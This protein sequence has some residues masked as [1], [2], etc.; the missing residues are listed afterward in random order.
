MSR[1]S[2]RSEAW[3]VAPILIA[4]VVVSAWTIQLRWE[5]ASS[6]P[7]QCDEIPLLTRFTGLN[8]H[9]TNEADA[10]QFEPSFYSLRMGA[11]RSLRVPPFQ[12]AIHTSTGF[13]S[14][15]S[16]HVLGYSAGAA[17][18]PQV[19]WSV[20]A[21]LATGW[22]AWLVSRSLSAACVAAWL[23]AIAPY[24]LAYGTQARGYAECM[25]LAP[26]LLIALEYF[27][28]RPDR[29][30]RAFAVFL[31]SLALSMTV[32][33]TWVYWVLPTMF[34]AVMVLP[35]LTNDRSETEQARALLGWILVALIAVMSVYTV[36]RWKQLSVTADGFGTDLRDVELLRAFL[37]KLFSEFLPWPLLGGVLAVVG[38]VAARRSSLRWWVWPVAAGIA[39]PVLLTLV[40]GSPGYVRNLGYLVAPLLI[41]VAVGMDAIVR[42]IVTRWPRPAICSAAVSIVMLSSSAAA[43]GSLEQ[44]ARAILYPDWGEVAQVLGAT[45]EPVGPRWLCVCL[46][47]YW[48]INWYSPPRDPAPFLAAGPGDTIEVAF[49]A[50]READGR[51]IV[52]GHE[53]GKI[54]IREKELPA[55]LAAFSPVETRS[56]VEIRRLRATRIAVAEVA[57]LPSGTPVF[58]LL[59]CD[60]EATVADWHALLG[61]LG[62]QA[63]ETITYRAVPAAEGVIETAIFPAGSWPALQDALDKTLGIGSYET[64]LFR[65]SPLTS[66][67][68]NPTSS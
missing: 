34:L 13:W 5:I 24:S 57:S 45:P 54:G 19:L 15:L 59:A 55:Y 7:L 22:A 35:R 26:A 11:L 68:G 48:Q 46:A 1:S 30:P 33:T 6:L 21:I 37:A 36:D 23:M 29:W 42:S 49:G 14:N 10:L 50:R 20:V 58:V 64:R 53:P 4:T 56:G 9:A 40:L 38:L 32:Y 3:A 62:A 47:N 17:R 65:L 44:R 63:R 2:A 66:K 16:I 12:Y 39:A 27:R 18:L 43:I 51:S 31:C 25:A 8:G 60:R 28:R 52:F 41:L 67:Y 61:R